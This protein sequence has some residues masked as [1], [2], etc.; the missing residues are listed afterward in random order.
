MAN[1][2][3]RMLLLPFVTYGI[4]L[5]II[6]VDCATQTEPDHDFGFMAS[7][8][9]PFAL[10]ALLPGAIA[11]SITMKFSLV[12]ALSYLI[13]ATLLFSLPF[14]MFGLLPLS[15]WGAMIGLC[16]GCVA[17]FTDKITV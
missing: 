7:L 16:T 14:A 3:T 9:L 5:L 10:F 17:I 13:G 15:W 4:G 6:C 8:M 12:R 1:W 11:V 2:I